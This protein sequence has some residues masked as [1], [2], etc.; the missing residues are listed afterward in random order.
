M[1]IAAVRNADRR[2][3]QKDED[4]CDEHEEGNGGDRRILFRAPAN[5]SQKFKNGTT[6]ERPR[7]EGPAP[8][9]VDDGRPQRAGGSREE[10]SAGSFAPLM[11]HD[12]ASCGSLRLCKIADRQSADSGLS[13]RSDRVLDPLSFTADTIP[14]Y[15]NQR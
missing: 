3:S 1:N 12:R 8:R 5:E 4:R 14:S 6:E 13:H 11:V 2:A 15:S 10:A 9:N 7:L